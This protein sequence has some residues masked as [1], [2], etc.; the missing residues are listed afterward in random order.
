MFIHFQSELRF[1]IK[2]F[3]GPINVV[4]GDRKNGRKY[5]V[6]TEGRKQDYVVTPHQFWVDGIATGSG[7]VRQF[8]ATETTV[9]FASSL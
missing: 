9:G 8:V 6:S 2:I 5:R 7:Q 4:S 3:L 1:A